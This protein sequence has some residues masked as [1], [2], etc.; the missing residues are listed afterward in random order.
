MLLYFSGM[1]ISAFEVW[2]P[3]LKNCS[4]DVHGA[5]HREKQRAKPVAYFLSLMSA[6]QCSSL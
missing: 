1:G 4:A 5:T 2:V 6:C 3:G